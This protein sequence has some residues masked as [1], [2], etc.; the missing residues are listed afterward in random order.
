MLNMPL[1]SLNK[2][3]FVLVVRQVKNEIKQDLDSI[4]DNK[5]EEEDIH[6]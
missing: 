2:D 3:Y 6:E 4:E 5:L 1:T